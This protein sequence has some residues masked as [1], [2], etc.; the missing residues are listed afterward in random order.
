MHQAKLPTPTLGN[1]L[2]LTALDTLTA[3]PRLIPLPF[4]GSF[5]SQTLF[6]RLSFSSMGDAFSQTLGHPFVTHSPLLDIS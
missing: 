3:F 6:D 4:L 2:Q 5:Y 1:L